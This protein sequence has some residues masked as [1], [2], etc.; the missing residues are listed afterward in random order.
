MIACRFTPDD[1]SEI[2]LA[3]V[4]VSDRLTS[5]E[6]TMESAVL[7]YPGLKD[8]AAELKAIG[9]SLEAVIEKFVTGSC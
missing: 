1:I 5:Y 7:R 2:R 4:R 8:A 3:L 9:G 6:G